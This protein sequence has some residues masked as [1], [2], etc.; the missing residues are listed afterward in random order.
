MK[1]LRHTI[2]ALMLSVASLA[3]QAQTNV[4]L[5]VPVEASSTD[6]STE[7]QSAR[8]VQVSF[9]SKPPAQPEVS[10]ND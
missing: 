5:G 4:F 10:T 7:V 3:A 1:H 2:A 8:V 6:P 9:G